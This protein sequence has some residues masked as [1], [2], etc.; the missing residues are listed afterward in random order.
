MSPAAGEAGPGKLWGGRFDRAP[1]KVF[2]EFQRSFS[3]DRRLLPYELAV[4]RAWAHALERVGILS[5]QEMKLTMEAL[6]AIGDR[7][8]REPQWLDASTAEDVHSFVE[9]ALVEKL[10]AKILEISFLI[11]LKFLNG[12]D[13]LKGQRVRS[14][15]V[16]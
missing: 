11:E 4:D 1:D 16:Y 13:R 15:V 2:Y 7:A 3:F 8:I 5:A 6:S 9:Q 12:R 10:G 14:L